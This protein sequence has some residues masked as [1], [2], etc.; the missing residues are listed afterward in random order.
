MDIQEDTNLSSTTENQERIAN[1]VPNDKG[2][3]N[4]WIHLNIIVII[5]NEMIARR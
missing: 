2:Y 5:A 1:D 3:L 4:G